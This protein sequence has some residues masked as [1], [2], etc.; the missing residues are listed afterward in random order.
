[1]NSSDHILCDVSGFS[2]VPEEVTI[3]IL[4]VIQCH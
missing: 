4:L 2:I 3:C 1:M